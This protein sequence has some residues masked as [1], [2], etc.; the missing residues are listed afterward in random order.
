M[1]CG[2]MT[3]AA[4]DQAVGMGD[5]ELRMTLQTLAWVHI[6]A[7]DKAP[8]ERNI[9]DTILFCIN[10]QFDAKQLQVNIDS[11]QFE[12]TQVV[13]RRFHVYRLCNAIPGLLD[14]HVVTCLMRT[15]VEFVEEENEETTVPDKQDSASH[16]CFLAHRLTYLQDGGLRH[17][18]FDRV[19]VLHKT[20]VKTVSVYLHTLSQ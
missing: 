4:I 14:C 18:F 2:Q 3:R 15:T 17:I 10:N 11:I 6:K 12:E 5:K 8:K 19:Q 7:L 20:I 9:N 13:R 1:M 16:P